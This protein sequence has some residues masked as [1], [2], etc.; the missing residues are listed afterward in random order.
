MKKRL[1]ALAMAGALTLGLLSGCGGNDG[2]K[3]GGD[4]ASPAPTTPTAST[5]VDNGGSA[6]AAD[7]IKIGGIGP[8]TGS[9]AVYGQATMRGAKVAVDEIN[10]LGGLQLSLDFQDDEGD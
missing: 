2:G 9:T 8:L 5:P 1:L 3:T 6:P 10:A 7:A 4:N